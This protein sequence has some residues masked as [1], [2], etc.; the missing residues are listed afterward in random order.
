MRIRKNKNRPIR[1]AALQRTTRR[2]PDQVT[3]GP[4]PR[5]MDVI[6]SVIDVLGSPSSTDLGGAGNRLSH[7]RLDTQR[8]EYNRE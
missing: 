1:R 2:G 6:L 8:E 4:L 5:G 7:D 3:A